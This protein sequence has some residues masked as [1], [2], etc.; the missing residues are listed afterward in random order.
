MLNDQRDHEIP[1]A[2]ITSLGKWPEVEDAIRD[3]G[4]QT[5]AVQEAEAFIAE[6]KRRRKSKGTE[7]KH[8]SG[9]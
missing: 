8:S 2:E 6:I 7:P 4:R 9:K 1:S 3:L 5:G